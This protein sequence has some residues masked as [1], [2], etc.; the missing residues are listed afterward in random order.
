MAWGLESFR[1][2]RPARQAPSAPSRAHLQKSETELKQHLARRRRP[3]ASCV[4]SALAELAEPRAS[5]VFYRRLCSPS[6]QPSTRSAPRGARRS[7]DP[8]ELPGT[9]RAGPSRAAD[10]LIVANNFS[11]PFAT[12]LSCLADRQRIRDSFL[13][14]SLIIRIITN[15]PYLTINTFE[16]ALMPRRFMEVAKKERNGRQRRVGEE[17]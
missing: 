11:S 12:L 3:T 5:F 7:G 2:K 16:R 15:I 8:S 4:T 6:L 13:R 17:T 9:D 10:T 14:R 1:S